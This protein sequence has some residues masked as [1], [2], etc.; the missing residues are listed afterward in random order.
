MRSI[1]QFLSIMLPLIVFSV[2][3]SYAA[4]KVYTLQD[5]YQSAIETNENVKIAEENF[6]QSQTIIDQAWSY[7]YPGLTAR[8]AYTRYN[9]ELPSGGGPFIFQP[10]TQFQ[11]L[12]VLRQPLYTG[13]RTLAALR[14]AET[15][16]EASSNN[17]TGTRQDTMFKVAQAYYGELKA[18]KL[19]EV[20]RRSLERMERHKKVAE[21]EAATRKTKANV[22]ALLRATT[23]VSQA[24]INLVRAEDALKIARQKLRLESKL[25]AD[26]VITEPETLGVPEEPLEQLKETA[27]AAR[28]DY[29]ASRQN[30]KVAEETVT[31]VRGA[32][33]PQLYAEAAA[34]YQSSHPET[35][36][37]GSIYYGG[38]RLQ[39]PLFEGGLMKAE[40]AEARSKVRQAELRAASLKRSIENE[41]QEAHI[42]VQTISSVLETAKLQLG[43]AKDNFSAV[44]GLYREGLVTSLSMIDAEQALSLAEREVVNSTYDQQLSILQL[45]KNIG[46]LG[47]K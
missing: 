31:I 23:L 5:A 27:F 20:S 26:A 21:R 34:Q 7:V 19:V 46:V 37:D 11:A 28:P 1:A 6:F 44:E 18:Q 25:P 39:I 9:E 47:K 43:Y 42:N 3:F 36:F 45:R 2:S 24:R 30:I 17:L 14:T 40:T 10:L 16:R 29:A 13:G 4:E 35:A 32:H 38:L 8:S 15:L 12:L 41:V 33:Y 22:S